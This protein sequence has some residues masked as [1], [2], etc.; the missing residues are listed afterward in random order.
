MISPHR[1]QYRRRR[2]LDDISDT[3]KTITCDY[4]FSIFDRIRAGLVVEHPSEM[5]DIKRE[6]RKLTIEPT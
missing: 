4:T 2:I 6:R 3:V 5:A 1:S